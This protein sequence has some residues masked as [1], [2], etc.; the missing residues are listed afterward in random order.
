MA[1]GCSESVGATSQ[2]SKHETVSAKTS[3]G[4][5]MPS[6][7]KADFL[8]IGTPKCGSTWLFFALGQ[9]PKICLSEPKEINYFNQVDF[10]TPYVHGKDKL[11]FINP[12]FAKDL[13][14][15]VIPT[16]GGADS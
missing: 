4:N 16:C 9:H 2:F 12:N 5:N 6:T 8:G 15:Y 13:A 10:A 7:F 1:I 14:W 11:P 3:G